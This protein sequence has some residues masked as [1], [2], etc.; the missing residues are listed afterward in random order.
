MNYVHRPFYVN[1]K[2]IKVYKRV[3]LLD[4]STYSFVHSCPNV[5]DPAEPGTKTTRT[6]AFPETSSVLSIQWT[7]KSAV[8]SKQEHKKNLRKQQCKRFQWVSLNS[9][10]FFFLWWAFKGFLIFYCV[11]LWMRHLNSAFGYVIEAP[12]FP[13]IVYFDFS[14]QQYTWIREIHLWETPGNILWQQLSP[15]WYW[16]PFDGLGFSEDNKSSGL[17]PSVYLQ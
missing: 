8:S 7:Y 6:K 14:C 4:E 5:T 15:T 2:T 16:F 11:M 1:A 10:R 3:G 17:M 9:K 13:L 12:H